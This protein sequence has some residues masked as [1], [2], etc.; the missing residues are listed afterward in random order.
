MQTDNEEVV[1]HIRL[2]KIIWPVLIGLAAV[3]YLI[4]NNFSR[5]AYSQINWTWNS[6]FWISMSVL[7]MV[8]RD[9]AY[10]IRIRVLTDLHLSWRNSFFVIMIWEFASAVAPAILGGGFIFAIF[11]LNREKVNMGKSITAIMVTTFLD[12]IFLAIMAPLV[13]YWVGPESLFSNINQDSLNQIDFGKGFY[14]SFWTIYFVILAYKLFVAYALFFNPR[15]VKWLLIK[16]FSMPWL[17]KWKYNALVTGNQLVI[18]SGGLKNKTFNYWFVS[19]LATFASWTARYTVVNCLLMAFH[20]VNLD[21][22]VIYARQVVM[23]I[24]MLGSPTPGGSGIAE[25][26]FADF[27]GEFT[28][29]KLEASLGLLWRLISYYP[30]LLIGAIIIPRWLRRRV[31]SSSQQVKAE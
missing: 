30:Y 22:F 14:Y 10:M 21:H 27:L 25:L 11:I 31:F 9:L 1:K 13:F 24:I 16:L 12:G 26:M 5:E 6:T 8:V 3:V 18:A 2:G 29:D 4:S 20:N 17:R 7:M 28:P 15:L 19:T 23:G